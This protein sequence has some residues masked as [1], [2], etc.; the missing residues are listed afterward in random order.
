MRRRRA[1]SSTQNKSDMAPNPRSFSSWDADADDTFD[2]APDE[3]PVRDVRDDVGQ[4]RSI[5]EVDSESLAAPERQADGPVAHSDNNPTASEALRSPTRSRT[6]AER[7]AHDP[8]LPLRPSEAEAGELHPQHQLPGLVPDATA[9]PRG[10]S[11]PAGRSGRRQSRSQKL[12]LKA[13][14]LELWPE[15]DGPMSGE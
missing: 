4:P 12:A 11:A 10:T 2:D 15:P 7:L 5:H 3:L 1:M 8:P 9:S 14:Q 6:R 13:A